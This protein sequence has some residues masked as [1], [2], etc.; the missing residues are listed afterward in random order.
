MGFLDKIT[1]KATAE[2]ASILE[3]DT[4]DVDPGKGSSESSEPEFGTAK[5]AGVKKVEAAAKIWSKK[6][7]VL[8]YAM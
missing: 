1:A 8:A 2:P 5:Q 7:L 3:K 4:G 6:D